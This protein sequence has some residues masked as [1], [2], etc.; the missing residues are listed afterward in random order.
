MHKT[1]QFSE[2]IHSI[3]DFRSRTTTKYDNCYSIKRDS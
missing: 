2:V 1:P 3:K